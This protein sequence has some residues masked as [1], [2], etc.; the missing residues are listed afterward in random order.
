MTEGL[1]KSSKRPLQHKEIQESYNLS[2][3]GGE[4]FFTPTMTD[5]LVNKYVITIELQPLCSS[6]P[7]RHVIPAEAGIQL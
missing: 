3:V 1:V 2:A 5:G 4:A 6:F 7:Q